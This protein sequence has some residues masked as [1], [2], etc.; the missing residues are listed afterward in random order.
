MDRICAVRGGYRRRHDVGDVRRRAA[1]PCGGRVPPAGRS[2]RERPPGPL[3]GRC[4]AGPP[5]HPGEPCAL[6]RLSPLSA[7][8]AAVAVPCRRHAARAGP[9][10]VRARRADDFARSPAAGRGARY[11]GSRARCRRLDFRRLEFRRLEFRRPEGRPVPRVGGRT[12]ARPP[13]GPDDAPA[14]RRNPSSASGRNG[15]S[16]TS[17]GRDTRTGQPIRPAARGRSQPSRGNASELR[18]AG[19]SRVRRPEQCA[20]QRQQHQ[21]R[22]PVSGPCQPVVD[23]RTSGACR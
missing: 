10:S 12:A 5:G 18:A 21:Q 7:Q 14:T 4:D 6:A 15:A 1:R 17:G 8:P 13:G 20:L 23:G 22:Q 9:F 3:A 19:P 16:G 2:G 11:P